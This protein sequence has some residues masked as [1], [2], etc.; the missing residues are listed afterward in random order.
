MAQRV[1]DFICSLNIFNV[2]REDKISS[3]EKKKTYSMSHEDISARLTAAEADILSG[4]TMACEDV[5]RN[6]EDR[7]PWL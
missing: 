7:C 6:I 2:V 3:A 4:N 1:I 5:H